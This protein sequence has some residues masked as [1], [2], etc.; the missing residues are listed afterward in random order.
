MSSGQ[1][2][3]ISLY[4]A[5]TIE[6][7]SIAS[8][9]VASRAENAYIRFGRA[10]R[11]GRNN[12]DARLRGVLCNQ[13]CGIGNAACFVQLP[14]TA[15]HSI[16]KPLSR[17]GPSYFD[18]CI[19]K[20]QSLKKCCALASVQNQGILTFSKTDTVGREDAIFGLEGFICV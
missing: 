6:A 13:I 20:E 19:V 3:P 11:P 2:T 5:N 1:L 10:V 7:N 4:R 8:K 14:R 17:K 9:S 12:V 16:C 18:I 15:W